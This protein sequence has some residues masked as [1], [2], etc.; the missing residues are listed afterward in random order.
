MK[1]STAL[2]SIRS[3]F[4]MP[5]HSSFFCQHIFSTSSSPSLASYFLKSHILITFLCYFCILCHVLFFFFGALVL[6]CMIVYILS[7]F[8]LYIYLYPVNYFFMLF[9][10][11][12]FLFYDCI[13]LHLLILYIYFFIVILPASWPNLLPKQKSL[14]TFSDSQAGIQIFAVVRDSESVTIT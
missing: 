11:L 2:M 9:V 1:L 6:F 4:E 7:L 10:H 3:F 12:I 8:V 13:F 14:A 5:L